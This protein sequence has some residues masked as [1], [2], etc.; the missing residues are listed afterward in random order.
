MRSWEI[1]NLKKDELAKS[2]GST[3]GSVS[4]EKKTSNLFRK[5]A[6]SDTHKLD[7]RDFHG[8]I[9]VSVAQQTVDVMGMTRFDELV[10]ETLQ[11]NF[12]PAV[13][14]Q[15]RSITI[16]GAISGLGIESSSWKYGLVHETILEIDVLLPDGKIVT[17][18]AT[19][20]YSDLFFGIPNSFG[21]LG[22]VVRAKLQ[23]FPVKPYVKLSHY[24]FTDKQELFLAI[25]SIGKYGSY[26]SG[27]VDFLDGVAFNAQE[28]Y[29]TVGQFSDSAPNISDYTYLKMYFKSIQN[30]KTDYLSIK[31]YIWRWDTDWFWCSKNIPGAQNKLLRLIFGKL[32][33]RS[34]F[35][36]RLM[37]IE[38]R[39]SVI[40]KFY[41]YTGQKAPQIETIIQDV[42]IPIENCA[43]FLEFFQKNIGIEPVWLC[44]LR[45]FDPNRTYPM[46]SLRNNQT[47]VN[48]GFWDSIPSDKADA[49]YNR[50][51]E[52]KV[53]E[54]GGHKSLYSTS[55]YTKEKFWQLYNG[56]VYHK[57]KEKYDPKSR[58]KNLY[59][60]T[61]NNL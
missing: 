29:L 42:E 36:S 15:L 9:E 32:Y 13:V 40:E 41:R 56:N 35:Y 25:E 49:Y 47:Y 21:T 57:L 50:L 17:A 60:K 31:D 3:S 52:G 45:S 24:G 46:Y 43:K 14:P 7:V 48:F 4:L 58:L 6:Q 34:T 20:D 12:M 37:A 33:L 51:I 61:V 19:N 2:L 26:K 16:G 53:E 11:F 23:I 10:D 54:L 39:Y 55:Y 18:T 38:N 1:Y 28:N 8:V 22:Y 59:D 5:R 27:S 30:R 44:P